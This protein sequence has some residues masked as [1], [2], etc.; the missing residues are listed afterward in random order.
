MEEECYD[1]NS[2]NDDHGG[3]KNKEKK[4]KKL[5]EIKSQKRSNNLCKTRLK[6]YSTDDNDDVTNTTYD[7]KLQ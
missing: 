1:D 5:K 2:K 6:N 3:E 7:K 4:R